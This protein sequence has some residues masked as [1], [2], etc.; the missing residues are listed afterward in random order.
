LTY[1]YANEILKNEL[2]KCNFVCNLTDTSNYHYQK[3]VHLTIRY[4]ILNVGVKTVIFQFDEL[5][6]ETALQLTEH[7][8]NILIK[9]N[10]KKKVIVYLNKLKVKLFLIY[11]PVVVFY[12]CLNLMMTFCRNR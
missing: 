8:S 4:F 11:S 2:S 7:I 1:P 12:F 5:T 9:W 6:G 10:I 3:M